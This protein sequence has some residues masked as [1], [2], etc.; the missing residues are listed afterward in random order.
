M[1]NNETEYEEILTRIDLAT[2][3][4]SKKIIIRSDSQL[5]VG[6]VNGEYEM[7]D[8]HMIKY[9]CLIK[10]RLESFAALKLKHIPRGLNERENAL[11]AMASS[12]P[13]KETVF[14]PVYY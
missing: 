14:L 9:V 6:Q 12:L 13:I 7:R 1:S 10:L 8:Q 11:A 5:V 2:S 3:I 4:S